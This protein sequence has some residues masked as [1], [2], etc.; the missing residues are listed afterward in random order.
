MSGAK[1]FATEKETLFRAIL[2]NTCMKIRS[3]HELECF[4]RDVNKSH[5]LLKNSSR[6]LRIRQAIHAKEIALNKAP[7]THKTK[8][9]SPLG[10]STSATD[11]LSPP[12]RTSRSEKPPGSLGLSKI[13]ADAID[14]RIVD[15]TASACSKEDSRKTRASEACPIGQTVSVHLPERFDAGF[16]K[17]SDDNAPGDR[18]LGLGHTEVREKIQQPVHEHEP[19][20]NGPSA[21]DARLPQ[22]TANDLV[23]GCSDDDGRKGDDTEL[24]GNLQERT[25]DESPNTDAGEL[26]G[27]LSEPGE[28]ASR[29]P[30]DIE[31]PTGAKDAPDA[32][33]LEGALSEPGE[34]A[35]RAPGDIEIPT[36]AKDAPDAGELE[37]ALSE[38]G[39]GASRAPG[40]IEIPT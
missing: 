39:E 26:E 20:Q 28:G 11:L 17:F 4:K 21:F 27:A 16:C 34:G 3:L 33:E 8:A 9:S 13:L 24:S 15:A 14:Q 22:K 25:H 30:G 2:Y 36:G 35:S 31:I 38:P 18:D 23:E 10:S 1:W 40:D 7:D 5:D 29:A 6:S 19:R 37:G 12:P 32:G